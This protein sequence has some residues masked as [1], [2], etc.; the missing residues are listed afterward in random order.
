MDAELLIIAGCPHADG[1]LRLLRQALDD[2]GLN[3]LPIH[4][5][6]INDDTEARQRSFT[7]SPTFASTGRDLFIDTA[8]TPARTCRLYHSSTGISPLPDASE[9]RQALERAVAEQRPA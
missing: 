7:G 1:A 4:T 8:S 9:L 3:D 6:V 2:I 5:T